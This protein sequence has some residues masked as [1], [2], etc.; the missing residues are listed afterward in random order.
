M[1]KDQEAFFAMALK[2]KNFYAKNSTSMT[3]VP[4]VSGFYTQLD[5][6]I[7][8]LIAA[9]SGS[10]ADLTGYAMAKT[11]KR[12]ALEIAAL[13]I[14]NALTSYAL[15]NNDV[16]LQ[17]RADFPSSKWYSCSEEELVTQ[18]NV[19]KGLATPLSSALVPFG[20]TAAD[21]TALD[22]ALT[23]FIGIISDPSLAAD[24][25]KEDNVSL[26]ERIDAIRT[27]LADKLDVLM[28]SFEVG[29]PTVY[30]LYKSARAI[31]SNGSVMAPTKLG[32]MAPGVVTALHTAASYASDTFYTIQ[33]VGNETLYF[34]LSNTADTEGPN[35]VL[36]AP[37]ETRTRLAD[38]L[39]P[40]G[41]YLVVRNIGTTPCKVKLWVE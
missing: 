8:Q 25:R 6:L 34:S 26:S 23:A 9:D 22:A 3:A 20:A 32:D 38:T 12:Q 2:V 29:N 18:G 17:K 15:I 19:V 31:D 30:A 35:P 10:R 41:V 14:S 13:K 27:L 7:A 28:R 16:V 4:A 11:A 39:A 5:G 37:G 40:T 1:T 21:V 33:N 36:L 24:K